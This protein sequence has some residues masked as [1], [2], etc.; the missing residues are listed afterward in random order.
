MEAG[1]GCDVDALGAG[2]TEQW[3]DF[4]GGKVDDVQGEIWGQVGQG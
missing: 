2:L 3:D 4:H 1:L